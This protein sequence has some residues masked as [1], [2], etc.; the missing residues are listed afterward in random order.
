MIESIRSGIESIDIPK[1]KGVHMRRRLCLIP[2]L[3]VLILFCGCSKPPTD[4]QIK[5]DL[6]GKTLAHYDGKQL[7]KFNAISEFGDFRII[8]KKT[9]NELLEYTIAS[10]LIDPQKNAKY[11]AEF[12]VMYKQT[13]NKWEIMHL[14]AKKF[15]G[16]E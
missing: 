12:V 10:N 6:I 8:S 9:K 5:Q 1:S 15:A 16:P 3:A 14:Y 7:W 2:A 11:S 4:E 13:N